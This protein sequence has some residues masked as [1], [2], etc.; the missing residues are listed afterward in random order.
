MPKVGGAVN[1]GR[2]TSW[3]FDGAHHER[4][5]N[6]ERPTKPFV[7]SLVE[8]CAY[9]ILISENRLNPVGGSTGSPRTGQAQYE[10]T[11][12]GLTPNKTVRPEPRRRMRIRHS[13]F[14]E[15]AQPRRWFDGLTTNGGRPQSFGASTFKGTYPSRYL[16]I[17]PGRIPAPAARCP[18]R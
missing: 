17:N 12:T 2:R 15:Q 3:C 1:P 16:P 18:F 9:V 13:Y 8:G 7:L 5:E 11:G 4:A 10:R 14:G 6:S